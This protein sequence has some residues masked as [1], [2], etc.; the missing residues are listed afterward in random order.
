[1]PLYGE[2]K[3]TCPDRLAE[4]ETCE[5]K[6]R[7]GFESTGVSTCKPGGMFESVRCKPQD[8]N[9]ATKPAHGS[10][11]NCSALLKSG[12]KCLP[13][14]DPGFEISGPTSCYAGHL[15]AATCEPIP[16]KSS[17][18]RETAPLN[19]F[20]SV[21]DNCDACCSSTKEPAGMKCW[22][23][24]S[25][26]TREACCNACKAEA[27][28]NGGLGDCPEIMK[29]GQI[30]TPTCSDGYELDPVVRVSRCTQGALGLAK[31]VPID[32]CSYV[33]DF[34]IERF[35]NNRSGVANASF[36]ATV[37]MNKQMVE[38]DKTTRN[39]TLKIVP[40]EEEKKYNLTEVGKKGNQRVFEVS[41]TL[42]KVGAHLAEVSINDQQCRDKIRGFTLMCRPSYRW[43]EVSGSCQK[44][45]DGTMCD[46][47]VPI[48]R[49]PNG[50]IVNNPNNEYEVGSTLEIDFDA[51]LD[52]SL[53]F[54]NFT[55]VPIETEI[56]QP[57]TEELVLNKTGTF[58]L[59]GTCPD[60]DECTFDINGTQGQFEVQCPEGQLEIGGKCETD[61]VCPTGST[62]VNTTGGAFECWQNPKVTFVSA[63]QR[64]YMEVVKKHD[65]LN[66]TGTLSL[67]MP[68][69]DFDV[70]WK[71]SCPKEGLNQTW[72]SCSPFH[73]KLEK[74]QQDADGKVIKESSVQLKVVV[75]ARGMRDYSVAGDQNTHVQFN[76]SVDGKPSLNF[77]GKEI[78]ME[79]RVRIIAHAYLRLND[80]T[81][82]GDKSAAVPVNSVNGTVVTMASDTSGT[83]TVSVK[84]KDCEGLE[85]KRL[86]PPGPNGGQ[87]LYAELLDETG[88]PIPG[89]TPQHEMHHNLGGNSYEVPI[90]EKEFVDSGTYELHI[91]TVS[92]LSLPNGTGL[93]QRLSA[94]ADNHTGVR[95]RF[96]LEKKTSALLTIG[97]II[98]VLLGVLLLVLVLV[99]VKKRNKAR[100]MVTKF[101]K[102]E[103]IVSAETTFE[104]WDVVGDGLC[105]SIVLRD[106][107]PGNSSYRYGFI[108]CF[109]TSLIAALIALVPKFVVFCRDMHNRFTGKKAGGL[110]R[111]HSLL[112]PPKQM[113]LKEREENYKLHLRKAETYLVVSLFEDLPMGVLD[114]MYLLRMLNASSGEQY[115]RKE[116]L[117]MDVSI[118]LVSFGTSLI[119]LGYKLGYLP[120]I[121]EL[122]EE[123]K[124]LK[125][126][127]K[128][129]MAANKGTEF[130]DIAP[131]SQYQDQVAQH[132]GKN[133]I[134]ADSDAEVND[135]T[136]EDVA[137]WM[138]RTVRLNQYAQT[139]RDHK[140]TGK[141][142]LSMDAAQLDE[143]GITSAPDQ[144]IILARVQKLEPVSN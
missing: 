68:E 66:D 99:V 3:G 142:L 75:D 12:E 21:P 13:V 4:G 71:A 67:D 114:F 47:S 98:S 103:S 73:G 15:E 5:P 107:N 23:P 86:T 90:G 123:R 132:N 39:V 139:I 84:P 29:N 64:L 41:D 121:K 133:G 40:R 26:L 110:N 24:S 14:C 109:A 33:A 55:L 124:R 138:T 2:N 17:C 77:N 76:S 63:I 81:L 31:C 112:N 92:T 115:T 102:Y 116:S 9:A 136:V 28:E 54:C 122:L 79:V 70:N 127:R 140:I 88:N 117:N 42:T 72:I 104:I 137:L 52:P 1:M 43:D 125:K 7:T 46:K 130:D 44:I 37:R 56:S 85:I 101:L 38:N 78:T 141:M 134:P 89:K 48:I 135:W 87:T 126:L 36:E 49:G 94:L 129:K 111:T 6:C 34:K 93:S 10:A 144:Q 108:G 27:P 58:F 91:F 119:M 51:K 11:G 25:G 20:N 95:F 59:R 65:H 16:T 100:E 120:K 118:L 19:C 32:F 22:E 60:G 82:T 45:I 113:A 97:I 128:P 62:R 18:P 53:E 143:Y 80:V 8:C 30:C 57:I 131:I 74:P 50:D 106:D 61:F 105:L 83:L 96:H 69:S 35:P